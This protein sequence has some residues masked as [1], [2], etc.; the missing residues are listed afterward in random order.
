MFLRMVGEYGPWFQI[1]SLYQTVPSLNYWYN[2]EAFENNVGE[3]QNAANKPFL[4]FAAS[5]PS[6][7]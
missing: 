7:L 5:F 1:L 6:Y 3:G 2:P 4:N